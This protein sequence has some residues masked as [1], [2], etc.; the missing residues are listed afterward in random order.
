MDTLEKQYVM[1][2]QAILMKEEVDNN[3]YTIKTTHT[4][5]RTCQGY[6]GFNSPCVQDQI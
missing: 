1:F 4:Q 6:R 3:T 2:A 5:D